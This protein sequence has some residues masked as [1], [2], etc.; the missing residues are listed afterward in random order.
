MTRSHPPL[1]WPNLG[2][3]RDLKSGWKPMNTGVGLV[4][5]GAWVSDDVGSS[6]VVRGL[7]WGRELASHRRWSMVRVKVKV[8]GRGLGR[9]LSPD[10]SLFLCRR[11]QTV[12]PWIPVATLASLAGSLGK[13]SAR[14]HGRE[15]EMSKEK[16]GVFMFIVF[17]LYFLVFYE[18][19]TYNWLL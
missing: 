5:R 15:L 1:I 6:L 17:L 10:R 16:I 2:K 4:G 18:L 13:G 11:I 8:R 7:G 12:A 9:D 19:S 14:L 3:I